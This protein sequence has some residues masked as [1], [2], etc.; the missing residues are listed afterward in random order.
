MES[1]AR[2]RT[3]G[4]PDAERARSRRAGI[5]RICYA[6]VYYLEWLWKGV[7]EVAESVRRTLA[8]ANTRSSSVTFG[9]CSRPAL[10]MSAAVER[11][12]LTSH[13]SAAD[14]CI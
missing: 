3:A 2:C 9:C 11:Q 14:D 4:V 12:Q 1:G 6:A 5:G 7:G 8:G 13:A 10:R